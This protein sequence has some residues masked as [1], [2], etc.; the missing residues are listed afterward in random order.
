MNWATKKGRSQWKKKGKAG[1]NKE[2]EDGR[3][4]RGKCALFQCYEE[5]I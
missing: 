3:W 4:G 5:A 1:Q 2:G